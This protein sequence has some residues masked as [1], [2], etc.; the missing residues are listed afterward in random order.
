MG[1]G[2]MG[3]AVRGPGEGAARDSLVRLDISQQPPSLPLCVAEDCSLCPGK[4]PSGWPTPSHVLLMP[5]VASRDPMWGLW[6]VI[7]LTTTGYCGHC[8]E[9]EAE[10]QRGEV[11]CPRSRRWK[12]GLPIHRQLAVS[13]ACPAV[14]VALLGASSGWSPARPGT[15][16]S[17]LCHS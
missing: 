4:G 3:R 7:P 8:T 15:G 1:W 6:Y 12:R 10:A 2:T 11:T 13:P 14:H 9:E 5:L 16:G 17:S